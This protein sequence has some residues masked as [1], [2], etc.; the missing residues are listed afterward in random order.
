MT[1]QYIPEAGEKIGE[2]ISH[3]DMEQSGGNFSNLYKK[4]T[5]YFRVPDIPVDEK[6]AIRDEGRYRVAERTGAYTYG[7]LFSASG[8]DVEKGILIVLSFLGL[9]LTIVSA[10][11]FYFVKKG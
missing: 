4:G 8:N 10:L 9:I 6:I 1:E 11:A 2:V 7:S 3:S 5:A